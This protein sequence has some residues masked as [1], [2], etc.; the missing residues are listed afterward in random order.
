MSF[1]LPLDVQLELERYAQAR[2]ITPGEAATRI[3]SGALKAKTRRSGGNTH[4]EVDWIKYQQLVPGYDLFQQLPEGTVEEMARNSRRI[5][6]EK[7]TP[8]G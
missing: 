4:E 2:H 5:R 6:A 1:E 7:M 8:R 3:I